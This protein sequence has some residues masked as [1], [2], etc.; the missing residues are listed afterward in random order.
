MHFQLMGKRVHGLLLPTEVHGI[1]YGTPFPMHY[2]LEGT[3][4]SFKEFT[5]DNGYDPL[6]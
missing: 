3:G 5:T 2:R 1:M 4:I 6:M